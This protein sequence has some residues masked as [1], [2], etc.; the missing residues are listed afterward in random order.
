MYEWS[1]NSTPSKLGPGAYNTMPTFGNKKPM[2]RPFGS[3]FNNNYSGMPIYGKDAPPVGTYNPIIDP[4]PKVAKQ[5][6]SKSKRDTYQEEEKKG[7]PAPGSYGELES[8]IPETKHVARI[9]PPRPEKKFF[10]NLPKASY[11]PEPELG[12][13]LS[14]DSNQSREKQ[15]V[16]PGTYDSD[17]LNTVFQPKYTFSIGKSRPMSIINEY[18]P[19]Q[20][21]GP[22]AY[23]VS[24]PKSRLSHVIRSS[25]GDRL[26]M[27]SNENTSTGTFLGPEPWAYAYPETSQA[28]RSK[29]KRFDSP[30]KNDNPG[31]ADYFQTEPPKR[32][33]YSAWTS[34][35]NSRRSTSTTTPFTSTGNSS[36]SSFSN[37]FPDET[38]SRS[39]FS[40]FSTLDS[41]MPPSTQQ[42]M[43]TNSQER[44][45][46]TQN[47]AFSV[48]TRSSQRE[49]K[50]NLNSNSHD[51]FWMIEEVE[52]EAKRPKL[53]QKQKPPQNL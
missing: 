38:S 7:V 13:K 43:L 34:M 22:G 39:S 47:R 25:A 41:Q 29:S 1:S 5:K 26:H 37:L 33:T 21:P 45:K 51:V 35:R 11:I 10:H 4:P 18:K 3:S 2:K 23:N 48:M 30:P 15:W 40:S 32:S 12:I 24:L 46:P 28:F 31:P 53:V 42:S 49:R 52:A 27:T 14:M 19:N 6:F 44:F 36:R 9:V 16:G 17:K 50:I 8:W 20:N